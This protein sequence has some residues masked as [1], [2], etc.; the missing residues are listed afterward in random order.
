MGVP[1]FK[2]PLDAWILQEIVHEVRPGAIVEIGSA[3]GGSTL[4][5]AHLLD[6]LGRGRVISVDL[7]RARFQARHPRIVEVTGDSGAP[8]T[9]ARVAALCEE[10]P[11]MVVHD[12]DHRREPL[13]ADLESYAPLVSVGSY[14]IVED[15]VIDLFE[16]GDGI[17]TRDQGP[18]F[19]IEE[20]LG[21]H[22]EFVVDEDR[23]RYLVTYNPRGYLKRVS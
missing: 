20:F 15:G 21:R 1:A 4:Y 12:G 10:R 13:L 5:L 19:A 11:V 23:E 16:A 22:P 2:N 8:E 6:L 17:G 7:D 18:L 14:L 9:R 3:A